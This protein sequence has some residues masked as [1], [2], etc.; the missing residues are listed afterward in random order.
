[1][2]PQYHRKTSL[3]SS[4]S[5]ITERHLVVHRR[6]ELLGISSFY[7]HDHQNDNPDAWLARKDRTDLRQLRSD[8]RRRVP[9]TGTEDNSPEQNENEVSNLIKIHWKLASTAGGGACCGH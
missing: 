5:L 2:L 3:V 4:R 1:M 6:T 7:A 9:S 8:V